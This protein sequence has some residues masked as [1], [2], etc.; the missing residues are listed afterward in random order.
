M[1]YISEE[2]LNRIRTNANIVDIISSYGIKLT[3]TG[4]DNYLCLCPFHDDH[5]PNMIVSEKKQIYTCFG[6]CGAGGN[7]FKFVQD[8]ENISFVEAV[9][10]VAEK[11]GQSFNFDVS[12]YKMEN[13]KFKD[14]YKLM[15]LS[16]KFF[17]NNLASADGVKAIEYLNGRGINDEIISTFRIGLATSENSLKA[18]FEKKDVDLELAYNL[19]LLNKVGIN[20]YDMYSD[21]IM[22]PIYN[23]Q[24]YLCGYTGRCY[25]KDEKNKYINTKETIIYKKSEILFNYYNAKEEI[26]K[27]KEIVLVEGNMDAISLSVQ[28]IKNVC[29]LMGV[30]LSNFQI[31][32]IKKTKAKIVLMLDSDNAGATATMKVGDVLY[33]RGLN[34]NVVRLSGSKD[35]DEYI[36]K[37]GLEA[38]R[39]N[40][41]NAKK[42][43]DFKIDDLIKEQLEIENDFVTDAINTIV[44]KKDEIY[45][46]AN[47]YLDSWPMDRLNKVDQAILALGIY[48]LKYTETPPVVAINEAVELS[49]KYSDEKVTKMINAVLDEVYHEGE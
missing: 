12:G 5:N 9:K 4:K 14:E 19:G 17:Q 7:V 38:L 13:N 36:R 25:L 31:E 44:L 34:V 24:G 18:F 39:E 29:A 16:L 45:E 3:K 47:K 40:I 2:E 23:S 20:Y 10:I 27:L 35:P 11:S 43:I 8:I 32:L 1:K 42:Y 6:G 49:K 37:N 28:G 30:V 33:Q 48:E 46:F 21:R 22:I 15:D 41:K 26:N